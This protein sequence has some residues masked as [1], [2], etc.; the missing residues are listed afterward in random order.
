M[1]PPVSAW[2]R[3]WRGIA[4]W[5]T[6]LITPLGWFCYGRLIRRTEPARLNQGLVL[7]LTGIEGRS[8]LNVSLLAGLIDGGVRSAVEIVDWTTGNK[9]LFL[10]HLRG[11]SRNTR[12]AQDLAVRIVDYQNLHPGRPVWLV[13]HSGG[14]GLSLLVASA[15]PEGRKIT[16]I[17]MLATA[18]SP[19]AD[20]QSALD[21]VETSIWN[22]YSWFDAFFLIFGTT[23]A[24]TVDGRHGPAAGAIG[25]RGHQAMQAMADGRLIQVGWSWRMLRQFNPGEHF[26]CVHRVFVA[27]EIAPL[28]TVKE[29]GTDR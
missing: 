17:V 18:V 25:L 15:L 27:E 14:G 7:V 2:V 4:C 5:G 6:F 20:I 21:R 23:V 28:I 10:L 24:G 9:L 29:G 8:F 19:A 13:G 1:S 22:F 26:G 3:L 16:G 11:L 12:V